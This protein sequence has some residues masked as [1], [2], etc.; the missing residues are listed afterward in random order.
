MTFLIYGAG[1]LAIEVADIAHRHFVAQDKLAQGKVTQGETPDIAFIDDFDHD[2]AIN[3][4]P[5]L[6]FDQACQRPNASI[7]I[8][9][10]EPD[11]RAKLAQKATDAGL[12]LAT[13][14]DPSATLSQSA[15]IHPG[16]IISPYCSI[17]AN[18]VVA[19]NA[20]INTGAIVGHDC[21]VQ[22]H[23][24]ISSQANLGGGVVVGEGAFVGMGALVKQGLTVGRNAIV[25]MGSC[26][27]Q[28]VPEGIIVVGSPA[29][30][31]KRNDAK[32]VFKATPGPAA[33]PSP[34]NTAQSH[35]QTR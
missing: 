6:S 31:V 9:I 10:G 14:I 27:H 33:I 8:G 22:P 18:A 3:G 30:A 1:G 32:R 20:H 12:T 21:V 4:I 23:A 15:T 29:R 2:R 5:V 19:T 26:V 11:V 35:H 34:S 7:V 16:A 13:I 25:S 24:A 17:Q 28:D